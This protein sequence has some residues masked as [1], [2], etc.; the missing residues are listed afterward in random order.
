[1]GLTG[2]FIDGEEFEGRSQVEIA[3]ELWYIGNDFK[4]PMLG[5]HAMEYMRITI[6][7]IIADQTAVIVAREAGNDVSINMKFEP[8]EWKHIVSAVE[9]AYNYPLPDLTVPRKRVLTYFHGVAW[10]YSLNRTDKLYEDHPEFAL[11][12]AKHM[13][14]YCWMN[15]TLFDMS[16]DAIKAAILSK[17]G[18]IICEHNGCG[19]VFDVNG[20]EELRIDVYNGGFR[21]CCKRCKP[22][23]TGIESCPRTKS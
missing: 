18:A 15:T 8:L 20:E 19:T 2:L 14:R 9:A 11:D 17:K 6:R 10:R 5:H 7:R 22:G 1:M 4:L 3:I 13:S 21:F 16:K 12:F 23:C